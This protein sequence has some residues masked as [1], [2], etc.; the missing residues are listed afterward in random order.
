MGYGVG[1]GQ[2]GEGRSVG[3]TSLPQGRFRSRL[4]AG[5]GLEDG[6]AGL[7]AAVDAGEVAAVDH[8]PVGHDL[9]REH[10]LAGVELRVPVLGDVVVE[11]EG[12]AV[13]A[14][15]GPA[16]DE[17]VVATPVAH[18]VGH[19]DR[20]G[21]AVEQVDPGRLVVGDGAVPDC[22]VP[23]DGPTA[24]ASAGPEQH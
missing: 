21:V 14:L 19:V 1:R 6:D 18:G 11:V 16:V 9:D 23:A 7:R 24:G 20:S 15:V 17:V 22:R 5:G 12:G 3:F 2:G 10:A 4:P 13:L 8:H